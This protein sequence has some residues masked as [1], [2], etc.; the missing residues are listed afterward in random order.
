MNSIPRRRTT[1]AGCALASCAVVALAVTGCGSGSDDASSSGGSSGSGD[2]I[3]VLMEEIS[4]T[5]NIKSLLSDFEQQTGITV[6]LETVPY[7]DQSS[8]ILQEF[9]Q[10]SSTYD[11]VFNDNTYGPGYF[12]SGYVED[13]SSY[14]SSDTRFGTLD[15][16]YE[17]YLTPMTEGDAVFGLPVYGE[18]TWLMY[19]TDLFEEYGID[20]APT[21]TDELMADAKTISE[22]SGG[23]VAGISMRGMAG[24]HAVYPWAG[25]LRSFGGSFYDADGN[26][27]IDSDAAVEATQY[28]ADLLTD[29][30]PA[31][32]GNFDWEQNRIAFTQG[33]VAMTIDA[34]ANGPYNEDS[35]SSTVA[36][37]VG[38]APIPY[39]EGVTP[40]DNT[41][42]S[43]NVHALYMN[44]KSA[45]KDAAWKFMSWAT[46]QAVQENAVD[47]V[48]AVGVT[49]ADVLTGDAYK[50]KYGAFQDAVMSQLTTGNVDYLPT[51]DDAN[52]II[53]NV[54]QALSEVLSGQS[55]AQD[56]LSTAAQNISANG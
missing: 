22:K 21:T 56:A 3:T 7:A 25:I 17:P 53:E 46:S 52:T 47:T 14:A 10:G 18:S 29:Y 9:A 1:R 45:H 31:G 54:G 4:Y 48:E 16:F 36:G 37:K 43:L 5:D 2:T 39:A 13:L 11:V 33:K 38:Y 51:G 35:S 49:N 42:N 44:A 50:E 34:T 30:G 19:R 8:R 6:N 12:S 20:G 24:I 15:D 28:W 55:S 26:L 41:D 27:A 40:G 23:E 32:V